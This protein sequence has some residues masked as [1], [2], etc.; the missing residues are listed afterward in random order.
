[1]KNEETLKRLK[2]IS[3]HLGGVIRMVEDDAYCIDVIRQVQA[4]GTSPS[5]RKEA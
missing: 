3:G 1:M 5:S 2:I 4:Y